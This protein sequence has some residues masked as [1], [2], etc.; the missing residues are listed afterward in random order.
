M[1][2]AVGAAGE[3]GAWSY[4]K[5]FGTEAHLDPIMETRR[6]NTNHLYT[7]PNLKFGRSLSSLA[8]AFHS[9]KLSFILSYLAKVMSGKLDIDAFREVAAHKSNSAAQSLGA[10]LHDKVPCLRR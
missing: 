2:R 3:S 9:G 7:S 5:L 8:I 10:L 4:R 1:L 6:P